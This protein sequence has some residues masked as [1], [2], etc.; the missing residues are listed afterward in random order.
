MP[1]A[2][3]PEP[4]PDEG[5]EAGGKDPFAD[6]VL[7]EDFVKGASVKE[8][9]GRTR[10]LSARWKHTPPV[11]PGGRRSVNDGPKPP[12]RRFGRKPKLQA[13]DPWGNPKPR[14]R[15]LEWRT[16]LFIVL[17]VVVLLAALNVDGLRNWLH[18][19][20]SGTGASTPVPTVAPE[21]AK[22]SSA[23]P[24]TD[25]DQPTVAHPWAGS[26]AEGWPNG[27]E[28]FVLPEAKAVGVFSAEEVAEQLQQV[29]AYLTAANL[30]PKVIAG[31][32]PDAA[33]ALLDSQDRA[34]AVAALEHPKQ[35]SNATGWFARFDPREA[36]M[37]GEVVKVQGQLTYEGDGAGGVLVHTDFTYVYPVA[38]GPD[39][40]KLAK[41]R[42]A[43]PATPPQQPAPQGGTAHPVGLVVRAS[44]SAGSDWTARTILRRVDDYRFYDPD[45]YKVEPKKLVIAKSQS[46]KGNS[47]CYVYDGFLH[48]EFAQFD[49]FDRPGPERTGPT[50]D[51]YDRSKGLSDGTTHGCGTVSRS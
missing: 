5:R 42:Q 39:A 31:A 10:M 47:A 9:S 48:P 18:R 22:P 27:A 16:P 15:G 33:L 32:R 49:R 21:T 4:R 8:Q 14:R 13:L 41:D 7:D 11:D 30:D 17:T 25:P 1:I 36:R 28:A 12:K 23:P 6:L 38:P 3:D 19:D 51:P 35:G 34:G 50:T 24:T 29:K 40:E 44:E 46:E 37:I 2:E 45:H 26:P 43:S 20:S